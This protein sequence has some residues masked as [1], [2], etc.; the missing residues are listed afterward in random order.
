MGRLG[1]I[2]GREQSQ[3]T[4]RYSGPFD[5]LRSLSAA[6][7]NRQTPNRSKGNNKTKAGLVVSVFLFQDDLSPDFSANS[8]G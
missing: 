6:Q 5:S 7:L 2:Q 8:T 3:L 4:T 1:T